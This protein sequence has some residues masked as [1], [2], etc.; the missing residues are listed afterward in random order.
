MASYFALLG[1]YL[2]IFLI[3]TG[4]FIGRINKEPIKSRLPFLSLLQTVVATVHFII[5][6]INAEM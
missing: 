3:S 2:F 5:L 6:C 1:V 4:I